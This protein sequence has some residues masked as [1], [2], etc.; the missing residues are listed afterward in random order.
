MHILDLPLFEIRQT[1]MDQIGTNFW[2]FHSESTIPNFNFG[3]VTGKFILDSTAKQT[4]ISGN[5]LLGTSCEL[6]IQTL[7]I[8]R[9]LSHLPLESPLRSG[10][11]ALE[12]VLQLGICQCLR[13]TRKT[14]Y[15]TRRCHFLRLF[16]H[17]AVTATQQALF[18]WE[19]K[20]CSNEIK[21][22]E[23]RIFFVHIIILI[24]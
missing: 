2:S 6:G 20:I 8:D 17:Q 18:I 15:C 16:F 3:Q 24:F 4:K 19:Q 12:R 5:H 1:K 23:N 11:K 21:L 22:T 7:R 9:N 14:K 10:R 13:N